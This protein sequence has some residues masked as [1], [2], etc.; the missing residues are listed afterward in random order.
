MQLHLANIYMYD[1]ECSFTLLFTI[2]R[3]VRYCHILIMPVKCDVHAD[4]QLRD[5]KKRK[6]GVL[7]KLDRKMRITAVCLPLWCKG[8]QTQGNC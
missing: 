1:T 5:L 4:E 3:T 6:V 2:F 7:G 8:R